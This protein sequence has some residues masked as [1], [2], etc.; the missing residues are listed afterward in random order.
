MSRPPVPTPLPAG[1]TC[2]EDLDGVHIR[3]PPPTWS[4]LPTPHSLVTIMGGLLG[5][6]V[7]FGLA[8][9]LV[10]R[11]N[12]PVALV[13]VLGFAGMFL[14]MKGADRLRA[15]HYQRLHRVHLTLT[16][17][18]IDIKH[19]KYRTTAY[20]SDTEVREGGAVS[21]W[22][23]DDDA[24]FSRLGS[25][26]DAIR[27]WTNQTLQAWLQ[28]YLPQQGSDAEVPRLLHQLSAAPQRQ[29]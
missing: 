3:L 7:A 26:P 13:T 9:L 29:P 11:L 6:A 20:L 12:L 19:R 5:F 16:P 15:W 2:R 21:L 25:Q 18:M 27:D 24:V 23:D 22:K 10:S 17:T 4:Q 8:M 1:V 14:L 28:Q